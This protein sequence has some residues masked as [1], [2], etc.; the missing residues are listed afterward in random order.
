[1]EASWSKVISVIRGHVENVQEEKHRGHD[2]GVSAYRDAIAK[3]RMA[4]LQ[5]GFECLGAEDSQSRWLY[6]ALAVLPCDHDFKVYEACVLLFGHKDSEHELEQA[7]QAVAALERWAI[8]TAA[9]PG[10]FRMHGA[11][12]KFARRTFVDAREDIC[13]DV[14]ERWQNYLSTLEVVRSVEVYGLLGLWQAVELVG[15]K[16]MRQLQP[17]D[18][19][20]FALDSSDPLYF[21]SVEAVTKL[22]NA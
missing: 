5:A 17:Y 19:V 12:S 22:Y 20:L 2:D 1:D 6:L 8:I 4:V 13:R 18:S 9:G 10:L 14:V 21:R 15:G 16:R 11:R 3:K 7:G